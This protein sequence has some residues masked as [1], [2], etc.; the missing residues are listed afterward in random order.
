[1]MMPPPK[2]KPRNA[3]ETPTG[4]KTPPMPNRNRSGSSPVNQLAQKKAAGSVMRPS[5]SPPSAPPKRRLGG[6]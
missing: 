3:Y 2:P 5:A 6:Y 1:M 4:P